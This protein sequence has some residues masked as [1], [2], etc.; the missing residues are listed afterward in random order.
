LLGLTHLFAELSWWPGCQKE[1][2][3]PAQRLRYLHLRSGRTMESHPQIRCAARIGWRG[4]NRKHASRKRKRNPPPA[5]RN[6]ARSA[7]AVLSTYDERAILSIKFWHS[8]CTCSGSKTVKGRRTLSRVTARRVRLRDWRQEKK[9]ILETSANV[10]R[11]TSRR[12]RRAK[13]DLGPVRNVAAQHVRERCQVGHY[14]LRTHCG[15]IGL[16]NR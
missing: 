5:D 16:S 11:P 15:F 10:R 1:K 7:P 2:E 14:S 12:R 4:E 9:N 3:R 6:P 13:A 8:R